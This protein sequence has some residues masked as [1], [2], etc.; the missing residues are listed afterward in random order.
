MMPR[1]LVMASHHP[2][3]D[4]FVLSRWQRLWPARV[5][6]WLWVHVLGDGSLHPWARVVSSA[7]AEVDSW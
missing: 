5:H 4:A 6:A 3:L 2:T 1:Y 7:D